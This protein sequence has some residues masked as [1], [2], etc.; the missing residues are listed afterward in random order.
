MSIR[1]KVILPYLLL[2][3]FVALTGAYVV[4]RLVT[5]SLAERLNNQ[6]LEA[7]RVVS[8]NFA[9]QEIQHVE[10]ARVIVFTR[11]M[12]EALQVEDQ[13]ALASLALPA[14]EGFGIENPLRHP[15]LVQAR[16]DTVQSRGVHGQFRHGARRPVLIR[17]M[18]AGALMQAE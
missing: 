9:R 11:G 6:L 4:T 1:I 8:D 10:N 3:L 7:G 14:S 17:A 13:T 15:I 2:T 16:A 12:G 5:D 18:T